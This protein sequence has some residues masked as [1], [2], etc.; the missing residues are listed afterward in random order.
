MV[1]VAIALVSPTPLRAGNLAY[2]KCSNGSTVPAREIAGATTRVD[3]N[4]DALRH[5]SPRRVHESVNSSAAR[6]ERVQRD[7]RGGDRQKSI[8]SN[9]YLEIYFS[10][11]P[12]GLEERV[13]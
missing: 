12:R 6:P 1:V 7:P 13:R 3:R 2:L 9:S 8:D 11:R 10:T 4:I 5:R